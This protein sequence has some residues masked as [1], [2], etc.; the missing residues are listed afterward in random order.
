[1]EGTSVHLRM[2]R[3]GLARLASFTP[4]HCGVEICWARPILVV[5]IA[6][7]FQDKINLKW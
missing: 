3:R 7:G 1:M 4:A 2:L 5:G 6:E